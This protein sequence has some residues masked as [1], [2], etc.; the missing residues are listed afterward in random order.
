MASVWLVTRPAKD[1]SKRFRVEFRLGGREA[2]TRYGGSFKRKADAD[3]RKRWLLGELAAKRVPDLRWHESTSPTFIQAAKNWQAARV[4]IAAST[5]DQHRIQLD[6]LLP[7]IGSR[8]IDTLKAQDFIDVV[9]QLHANGTARETIRKTLGAGAMALDHAGVSPNPARDRSIKLPREEP[10]QINPP[11]AADVEK[12]FRRIPAKHR[13]ALLWLDWSGA[14]VSSIDHTLVSDYD[15]SRKRVRLRASTT[16]TRRALWV[17]L[18]PVLAEAIEAT[19]PHRRFRDENARLF[20]DSGADAL[21]TA[22]AKA[23]KAEGIALWSPHDLRHRRIS[24]LHLCGV[25]WAR[26]A[27]FVGQRDLTVTANVYSHVMLDEPSSTTRSC[28]PDRYRTRD[29]RS[30][31]SRRA[32]GHQAHR[33]ASTPASGRCPSAATSRRTRCTGG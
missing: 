28:S 30:P 29:P 17:E 19:L 15:Q 5:R 33:R 10:E 26:I 3:E 11:S 21:R 2:P 18:H 9:A 25:P 7:L 20:A 1:G 22:I 4:D 27:E 13:L 16:K 31:G 14:R 23:C 32:A 6:K 8:R 12:A 24:L